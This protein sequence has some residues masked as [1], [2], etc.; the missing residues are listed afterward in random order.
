MGSLIGAS[1][2]SRPSSLRA[3][4]RAV[5]SFSANKQLGHGYNQGLDWCAYTVGT[6]RNS[7]PEQGVITSRK[8]TRPSNMTTSSRNE[9]MSEQL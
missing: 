8:A 4:S 5:D 7:T 6:M 3:T 2:T 1:N 9:R